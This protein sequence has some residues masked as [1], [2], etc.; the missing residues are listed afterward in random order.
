MLD[1]S[2]RKSE[3][4]VSLPPCLE[5]EQ[6]VFLPLF[7]GSEWDDVLSSHV[8]GGNSVDKAT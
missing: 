7:V 8:A 1:I 2:V 6:A 3:D 4:L 5:R